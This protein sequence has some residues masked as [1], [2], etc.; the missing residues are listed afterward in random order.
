MPNIIRAILPF[1]IALV[2]LNT[3]AADHYAE[4]LYINKIRT[5]GN[6][7]Q[8]TVFDNTIEIWF[9]APP[10]I[11]AFMGCTS[12]YRA[13]IDARNTHMVSAAYIAYTAGKK[14]A[15]NLDNTLPIRD[16]SCEV[17][18]FDLMPG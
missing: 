8:G 12:S 17:S 18:Y 16:N 1:A 7:I 6:Y 15:I 11:P 10:T 5:V 9:T 13:Y 3:Q 2:V 4:G 14:V